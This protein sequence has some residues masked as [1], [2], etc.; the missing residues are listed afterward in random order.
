MTDFTLVRATDDHAHPAPSLSLPS[1]LARLTATDRRLL[2]ILISLSLAPLVL[3]LGLG[4]LT[5]LLRGGLANLEA[6]TAYRAL[7]AHGTSAFFWWL[8]IAQVASMLGLA[9]GESP[10]GLKAR[11]LVMAGIVALFAGMI[12]SE[13][14]IGTRTPLLYDASPEL[15]QEDPSA[16]VGMAGGYLLLALGLALA[17]SR[18]S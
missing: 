5:A 3:G 18:P 17:T 15:G 8:Y 4:F 2:L 6:E 11:P 7:T 14:T 9:A 12:L 10:D 13:A 1:A 16:V